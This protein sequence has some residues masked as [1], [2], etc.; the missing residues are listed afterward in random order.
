MSSSPRSH[1]SSG[2]ATCSTRR[3]IPGLLVALLCGITTCSRAGHPSP[4]GWR[5]IS[6]RRGPPERL[7]T[8]LTLIDSSIAVSATTVA[9][10]TRKTWR[11]SWWTGRGEHGMRWDGCSNVIQGARGRHLQHSMRCARS[12]IEIRLCLGRSAI[13]FMTA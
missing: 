5:R 13:G 11:R 9:I 10:L 4:V 12:S 1:C 2:C 3:V 8:P 6:S 7:L